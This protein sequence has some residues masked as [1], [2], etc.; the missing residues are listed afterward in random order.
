MTCLVRFYNLRL[1][2]N[3]QF[4]LA[5]WL[6]HQI[7]ST[8][9]QPL[10]RIHA[11]MKQ[12]PPH[13]S[14]LQPWCGSFLRLSKNP[15]T[16]VFAFSCNVSIEHEAA[17][18]TLEQNTVEERLKYV[19]IGSLSPFSFSF[20]VSLTRT[21]TV[22]RLSWYSRSLIKFLEDAWYRWM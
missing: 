5:V 10:F 21:L 20:R 14:Y 4:L 15:F 2:D 19:S 6:P 17:I 3:F 13:F 16:Q 11:R 7:N 1:K 9:L 12:E 22:F 18:P 8:E